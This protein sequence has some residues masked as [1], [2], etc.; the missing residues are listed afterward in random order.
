MDKR[1]QGRANVFLTASLQTGVATIPVRIRNIS[2]R[3]ALV[4]AASFPPI[5]T[6]VR[7]VRG[8]LSTVGELAWV[9]AGQGGINLTAEI[10]PNLWVKRVGASGQPRVDG[11]IAALRSSGTVPTELQ[12]AGDPPSLAA[13]SAE[14]DE[15]CESLAGT[16]NIS[17]ELGE[18]LLKLDSVAQNLR[19]FATGSPF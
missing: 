9:G 6:R 8:E 1:S 11:V 17:I 5:G 7:L 2:S 13:I 10:K 3:G 12:D 19:R 14:L 16:P 15:V 18:N 4:E